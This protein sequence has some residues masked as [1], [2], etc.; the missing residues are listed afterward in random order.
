MLVNDSPSFNLRNT[1]LLSDFK[2]LLNPSYA[3]KITRAP[4]FVLRLL[5]DQVKFLLVAYGVP[6]V[7]LFYA[8]LSSPRTGS[9]QDECGSCQCGCQLFDA[10]LCGSVDLGQEKESEQ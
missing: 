9:H 6:H 5:K 8:A 4:R 2:Q 3:D 7:L 10:D 1:A